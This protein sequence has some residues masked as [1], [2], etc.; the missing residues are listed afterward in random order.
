MRSRL[1]GLVVARAEDP[2]AAV[3]GLEVE[4]LGLPEDFVFEW[5]NFESQDF[6]AAF[7]QFRRLRKSL[8]NLL[9]I[10]QLNM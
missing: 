8:Q 2:L 3:E 5:G 4:A 9:V 7:A 10:L 6:C 1:L